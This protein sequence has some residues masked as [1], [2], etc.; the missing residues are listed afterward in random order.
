[1]PEEPSILDYLRSRL[2]FWERGEKISIPAE[3]DARK[4]R[5]VV[6]PAVQPEHAVLPDEHVS[7]D[8]PPSKI[9]SQPNRWPWRSLLAL[10]IALVAQRTWEPAPGRMAIIGLA[11]YLI[12][13]ALLVWAYFN[14][15]VDPCTCA[16]T[17]CPV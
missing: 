15:G 6:A 9:A 17:G 1:M 4:S 11:L 14:T 16:G 8:G 7:R 2:K 10:I 13:L 5:F 3:P 12:S